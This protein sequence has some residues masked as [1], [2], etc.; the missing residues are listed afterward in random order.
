MYD[1]TKLVVEKP[2]VG[3]PFPVAI[4]LRFLVFCQSPGVFWVRIRPLLGSY[5]TSKT[6]DDLFPKVSKK[7]WRFSSSRRSQ[8]VLMDFL[9]RET[10]PG[11]PGGF[12]GRGVRPR[13]AESGTSCFLGFPTMRFS[14]S[15]RSQI[16]FTSFF[17][18]FLEFFVCF[19][20]IVFSLEFQGPP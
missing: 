5:K 19:V 14:S 13:A 18:Y 2:G 9:G 12:L 4:S 15:R 10:L 1:L 3:F 17:K 11:E 7:L 16:D 20:E 8:N 6:F